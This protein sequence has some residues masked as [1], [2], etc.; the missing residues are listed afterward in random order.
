MSALSGDVGAKHLIGE[1]DDSVVEIRMEDD[2]VLTDVDSPAALER[3]AA[4]RSEL[5]T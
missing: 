5:E 3:L 2:A 4:D 1:H